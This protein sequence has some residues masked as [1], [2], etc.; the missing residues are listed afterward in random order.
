MV[1]I[2]LEI[3]SN[4]LRNKDYYICIYDQN[5]YIYNYEE[6][7]NF[8]N[9]QIYLKLNNQNIIIKGNDLHITK[10]E[11]HELLINGSIQGVSYE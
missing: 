8:S 5:I 4:A 11:N 2:M 7:L 9:N 6:I 10:M 1:I 3:F